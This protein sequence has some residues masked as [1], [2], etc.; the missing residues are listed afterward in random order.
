MNKKT[1]L[2]DFLPYLFRRLTTEVNAAIVKDLKPYGINL[3]RWRIIVVLHFSGG[4]NIGE[5]ANLTGLTQPGTS[6]VID[7]LVSEGIVLRQPRTEDNRIMWISLTK[8]GMAL[9]RDIFPLLV[10]HE[11]RLTSGFSAREKQ[12]MIRLCQRMLANVN[13]E[14]R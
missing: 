6:Q 9:F 4:A 7:K 8:K 12:D 2:L 5:L 10:A 13:K 1:P 11:D 3:P 14:Y